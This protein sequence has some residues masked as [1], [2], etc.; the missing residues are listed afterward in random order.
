[1]SYKLIPSL[2]PTHDIAF[3][4]LR[5]LDQISILQQAVVDG[6]EVVVWVCVSVVA[7]PSESQHFDDGFG[8]LGLVAVEVV[9]VVVE[10]ALA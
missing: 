6:E 5:R 7:F 10:A 1:M 2:L 4:L 3:P 9:V 8:S